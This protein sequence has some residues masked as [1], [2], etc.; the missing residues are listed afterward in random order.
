[1]Q[2]DIV[3]YGADIMLGQEGDQS[4]ALLEA[5]QLDIVHMRIMHAISRYLHALDQA[6]LFQRRQPC[7]VLLPAGHARGGDGRALFQLRKQVGGVE[8]AGQER[9][10]DIHP[11][12]FIHLSPVEAAAVRTFFTDNL[13]AF[14][15][16]RVVEN[17]RAALTH[18]VV[19]GFVEA[20]AAHVAH[21]AGGTVLVKGTH[22]LRRVLHHGQAMLARDVAQRVHVAAHARVVHRHNSARMRRNRGAYTERVQIHGV[23]LHIHKNDLRTAQGKG[24][25]SAH[26][27][28][29]RHDHLISRLDIQQDGRH[30]Q[31]GGA[32]GGQKGFGRAGQSLQRL[33]AAGGKGTVAADFAVLNH[34]RHIIGTL[35]YIWGNIKG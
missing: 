22:G 2:R 19:L 14:H 7:V 33:V 15:H 4:G 34:L 35:R 31:R 3:E 20:E 16:V 30:F 23:G 25:G 18:G 1:M 24:V 9:G 17:D 26:K 12:V 32:G 10:T 6:A 21:G 29:R 27:G 28:K 11:S 8:L 13:G 5:A